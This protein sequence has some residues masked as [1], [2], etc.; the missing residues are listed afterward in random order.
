MV[1]NKMINN[2]TK[3]EINN[4]YNWAKE[5]DI[6]ELQT[7]DKNKLL[8]IKE[9]TLGKFFREEKKFSYIPNEIFKLTNL[10]SFYIDCYSL[11]EFPK[12]I[13]KLINL[14]KLTIESSDIKTL[15][16]EIFNLVNLE[17]LN[18]ECACLEEFPDGISNLTK[19]KTLN[20]I[21]CEELIEL[22]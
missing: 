18:I 6:K 20:F 3:K 2:L 4:L 16:K 5:Y 1:E 7:K 22:K 14:K 10:E 19:L 17:T 13:E 11:E 15:P 12:D 8:N 9:L 21:Y